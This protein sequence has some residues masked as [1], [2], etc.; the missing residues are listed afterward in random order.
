MEDI[1]KQMGYQVLEYE[2]LPIMLGQEPIMEET[3]QLQEVQDEVYILQ[4]QEV[5]VVAY[6]EPQIT[7]D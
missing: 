7:M 3:S 1:F 6:M 2:G 5:G 4:P